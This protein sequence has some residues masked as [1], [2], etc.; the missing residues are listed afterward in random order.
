MNDSQ[1]SPNDTTDD[2]TGAPMPGNAPDT[3]P[4]RA[5]ATTDAVPGSHDAVNE[6]DAAD[7]ADENEGSTSFYVRRSRVPTLGFWVALAIAIPIAVAL[8]VSP[9]LHFGDLSGVVNFV[10]VTAVFVGIPLAAVAAAVD[11][12]RHRTSRRRRR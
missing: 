7:A 8:V 3:T 6:S 1:D 4:D 9:F 11:A 5:G 2:S 10:L 12:F